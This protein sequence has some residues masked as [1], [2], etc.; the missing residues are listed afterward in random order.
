MYYYYISALITCFIQLT[1]Y[2]IKHVI[3]MYSIILIIIIIVL[4]IC[5]L[6]TRASCCCLSQRP[7]ASQSQLT[8]VHEIL[9]F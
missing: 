2:Q 5:L 4:L 7:Y 1:M 9:F 8:S 6:H 3:S